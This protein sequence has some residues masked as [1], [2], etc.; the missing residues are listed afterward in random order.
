VK[1]G[2]AE[3]DLVELG[4]VRHRID[5][6][7]VGILPNSGRLGFLLGA[8]ALVFRC[9]ILIGIFL[10]PLFLG[11]IL[12]CISRSCGSAALVDTWAKIEKARQKK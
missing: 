1:V 9:V 3:R 11:R 12:L 2:A 8:L 6:H 7:P 4:V 5:V 10:F